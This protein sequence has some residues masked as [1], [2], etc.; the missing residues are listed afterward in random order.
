MQQKATVNQ[1]WVRAT[2]FLLIYLFITIA[3][4]KL[5]AAVTVLLFKNTLAIH[6]FYSA[7]LI[8]FIT[9]TLLVLLFRKLIDK[10][11]IASLGLQWK[12]FGRE[13]ISGFAS[14]VLLITCMATILWLM[15]LLQWFTV[16]V[17]WK[18]LAFVFTALAMVAFVEEL[19]FRGYV[20]QN[21]MQRMRKTN[22]LFVSAVLFALFHSMNPNFNLLAFINIFIAGFLLGVNYIYTRNLWFSVFFHFSWN[23][24]QGPVLG[25]DVSGIEL[26]SFMQQNLHGSILLTG[27]P[28]GL[29]ASWL[30]TLTAALASII[31]Y[32]I[33]QKKY[34]V[35]AAA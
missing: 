22:A 20:L 6:L 24:F 16:T 13:R 21:L 18:E 15:G 31:L 28:F 12:G 33:F 27:G 30:T 1:G 5:I 35:Q 10:K 8:N 3:A 14:G 9:G 11:S 32:F 7:I 23:F 17:E 4:S 34:P 25:F 29:E 26:P 19:V 2:A